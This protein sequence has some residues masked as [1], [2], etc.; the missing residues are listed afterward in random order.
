MFR[1]GFCM[2]AAATR[3]WGDAVVGHALE[4]MGENEK[5]PQAERLSG[6]KPQ[7]G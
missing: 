2:E 4:S 3:G 7:Q 1:F 6:G 5:I